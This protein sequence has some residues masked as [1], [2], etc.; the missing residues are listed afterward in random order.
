M[1]SASIGEPGRPCGCG[2]VVCLLEVV[3][4][5]SFGMP[6]PPELST[7]PSLDGELARSHGRALLPIG[8]RRA[9]PV[10]PSRR[11][12]ASAAPKSDCEPLGASRPASG[13]PGRRAAS[14]ATS[15]DASARKRHPTPALGRRVPRLDDVRLD[16]SGDPADSRTDSLPECVASLDQN[17]RRRSRPDWPGTPSLCLVGAAR[18]CVGGRWP[19]GAAQ[20]TRHPSSLGA[21]DLDLGH[22]GELAAAEG[23]ERAVR[24]EVGHLRRRAS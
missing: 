4:I 13:R 21:E 22:V 8:D 16:A 15:S 3:A 24:R 14:M 19:S 5:A 17:S 1:W 6:D 23:A 11:A 10:G 12:F 18:C 7:R 2:F 20:L 9:R